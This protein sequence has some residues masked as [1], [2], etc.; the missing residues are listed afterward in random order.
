MIGETF[1]ISVS[2][3][4]IEKTTRFFN[5]SLQDTLIE[6]LQNSRRAGATKVDIALDGNILTISDDGCG[7]FRDVLKGRLRDRV[8]I[9]L[10]ESGW[11]DA[12][13][14]R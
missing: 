5:A 6:L 1:L 9:S 4:A 3:K 14:V 10:G 2:P 11:D 13:Q 8:S 7:M 12:T